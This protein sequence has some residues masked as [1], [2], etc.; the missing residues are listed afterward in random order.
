[1]RLSLKFTLAFVAV[2][3]IMALL[4][5][6]FVRRTNSAE[7]QM[8]LLEQERTVLSEEIT[9]YYQNVGSWGGLDEYI[10][11]R[12]PLPNNPPAVNPNNPGQPAPPPRGRFG[13]ADAAG[14]A[15]LPIPPQIR[16]GDKLPAGLIARAKPVELEGEIIA[17]IIDLETNLVLREEEEIFLQRT[18]QALLWATAGATLLAVLVG[19][20]LT[21][22]LLHPIRD[23]TQASQAMAQGQ[24]AQQV[25]VRTQDELGEL[26]EAFNQ[27]SRDLAKANQLR[28]QMTADIAHDLRT[29][30]TVIAGYLES[31]QEGVLAPTPGRLQTMYQEVEHLL[32][33]VADLQ[34]L[35]KADAG[36]LTLNKQK[37]EPAALLQRVANSYQHPAEQKGV[38]LFLNIATDQTFSGDEERLVQVLGNLV[39]NALRYTPAGGYIR[40]AAVSQPPEV[41]LLVEDNGPGIAPE[42]LPHIF[43][44]FYRAD[45]SRQGESGESGLGLAIVRSLVEAHGGVVEVSS[46]PGA[47]CTFM[48]KLKGL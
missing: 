15:L 10:R 45:R 5:L 20:L 22:P 41:C 3:L 24:L 30:L 44:R 40:L 6:F 46:S 35:A 19:F 33:L 48:V 13:I 28:R 1:M 27:M 26:A 36:E 43:D 39:S 21:R 37:L 17:Y 23:L 14:L 34:T 7:L 32:H 4:T 42:H 31:M 16:I 38:A 25:P 2:T 12:H 11:I 8:F 29:P 47:G 9:A 18:N